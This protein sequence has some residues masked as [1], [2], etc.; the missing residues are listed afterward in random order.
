MSGSPIWW[1]GKSSELCRKSLPIS[2]CQH[3]P[4]RSLTDLLFCGKTMT[5]VKN[6]HW[7]IGLTFVCSLLLA[8]CDQSAMMGLSTIGEITQGATTFEGREVKLKGTAS[9]LL[10]MPF[11]ESKGYRLKDSTGEIVVWTTGLMPGEG[12][13][14]IVRGRVENTVI[15]AGQSYGLA[16]KEIERQP[17]GIKWPWK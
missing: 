13:E 8:A 6:L 5:T 7:V 2:E 14:V 15:L 17:P 9:Q 11:T 1:T 3:L 16:L 4:M 10:K 12:E